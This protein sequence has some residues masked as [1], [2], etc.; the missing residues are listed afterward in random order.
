[1]QRRMATETGCDPIVELDADHWPWMS[2]P[3]AF[4]DAVDRI[5]QT[6]TVHAH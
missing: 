3:D 6:S 2:R 5:V 4:V 1:M